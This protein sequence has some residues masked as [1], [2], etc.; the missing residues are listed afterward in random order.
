MNIF[1]SFLQAITQII[2]LLLFF[3]TLNAQNTSKFDDEKQISNYFSGVLLLNKNQY[4]QSYKF[5]KKLDGLESIHLD[6]SQKYLYTL[7]NNGKLNEA[8][9]YSLKLEKKKLDNY[10]SNLI[11]GIYYLKN[12]KYTLSKRHFVKIKKQKSSFPLNQFLSNSLLNWTSLSEL[13][14]KNAQLRFDNLDNKFKNLKKIQDAFLNCFYQTQNTEIFYEKLNSNETSDFSRYNYFYTKYLIS[15]GK[16]EKAKVIK[17]IAISKYPRN[18]L[19][20]QLSFDLENNK[21]VLKNDFNCENQ[22][23]VVAEIFYIVANAL[24]QQSLL[25]MSN[26]Y[27]NLAKYLNPNFKAFDTL[28]AENFYKLGNFDSAEKIYDRIKNIGGEFLWFS[29]KQKAK[30]YLKQNNK[31]K[32]INLIRKTFNKLPN[33][34]I[35]KMFDIAEFL[36]NND[37]FEDSVK[38]YTK[39]IQSIE[40]DHPLYSEVTDGRGVAYERLGEWDKAEKDLLASL[41]ANPEQAYVINYLAY[42]WIEQGVNIERSLQM[43]EKANKLKSNDPYIIDSLG[44]ALFKLKKFE[45]SKYYLQLAVQLMPDDPIVNDHYGDALWKNKE[46]IQARYFW[47][48][49]LNLEE[50]EDKLKEKVRIKLISG[51]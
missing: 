25:N 16:I 22:S 34:E 9:R 48:Y 27:L 15:Q 1:K 7:I 13:N 45:E 46:K 23:H 49:V 28:L 19:L 37:K 14:F 8:F 47:N 4:L 36:K 6:Y 32:A 29:A 43:L 38:F 31:E 50:A 26:F 44:W 24:S 20:N 12:Q 35:Y 30:I 11:L 18:L 21:M 42:S 33:T 3:S 5:L 39:I 40:K 2:F 51:L 10:E 41:E 17:D